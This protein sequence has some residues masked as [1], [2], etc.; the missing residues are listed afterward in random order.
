MREKR[1][2]IPIRWSYVSTADTAVTV[3]PRAVAEV[4]LGV[5]FTPPAP[6]VGVRENA[7]AW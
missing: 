7:C 2:D 1:E 3:Q 4:S 6:S 5:F